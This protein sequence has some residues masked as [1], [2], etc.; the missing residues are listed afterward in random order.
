MLT[1]SLLV[2]AVMALAS[3]DDNSTTS[4]VDVSVAEDNST[5]S[6]DVNA[7]EDDSTTSKKE[8]VAPSCEIGWSEFNG[9]CFLFVSTE[10]SWA[11]AEK[12][13]LHKKGHLASV[14]N[15]EEYK[16]IQAV[17]NAHT[18]GHPT[19]WV[20]GSDCQKEGIWL[21]SDGSGFEFDSWCEGQPDNYVGAESCLQINANES[22]CWNDF[23][24][25][26]VLPSVC[27]S[28]PQSS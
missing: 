18:G 17:V 25:S 15:E 27:A 5:T 6:L 13:C 22:H 4:L 10:M 1:V 26:T 16:H 21:W 12:N 14:H 23:P 8:E 9:R 19:T 20:G 11:D 24:C 28:V 3:A 7:A 2:C